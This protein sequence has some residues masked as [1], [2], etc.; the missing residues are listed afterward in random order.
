[1]SDVSFRSRPSLSRALVFG[2][3]A[4][5]LPAGAAFAQSNPRMRI[6]N[7]ASEIR[8]TRRGGSKLLT[9][10]P[11]GTLVEV[12]HASGD[13]YQHLDS[14]WYLVVLPPDSWGRRHVGW[15]SGKYVVEAPPAEPPA[16]APA[17]PA[18]STTRPPPSVS[19]QPEMATAGFVARPPAAEEA[20]VEPVEIPDV[21]VH[22]AFDKSDLTPEAR[23]TLD[24]AMEMMV[25]GQAMAFGVEGHTDWSGPEAYNEKLG[26]ARAEAVKSYLIE[27]HRIPL[28]RISLTSY[29]ESMPA[30]SN[31]TREG[32]A[33]NRRVV[34][35][36]GG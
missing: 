2:L 27:A 6:A 29:G 25:D 20:P 3:A 10:A 32:R 36:V 23:S 9:T 5:L 1:M 30:A 26:M 34:V 22:F 31:D 19:A 21:V 7:E 15:I 17:R 35:K 11:V 14:N 24:C 4:C 18:V 12:I 8:Q 16:P 28:D 33:Q 13:Y